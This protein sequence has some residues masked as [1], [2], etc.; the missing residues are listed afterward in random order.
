MPLNVLAAKSEHLNGCR[1]SFTH[2]LNTVLGSYLQELALHR[3][4]STLSL[5]STPEVPGLSEGTERHDHYGYISVLGF[6]Q[7]NITQGWFKQQINFSAFCKMLSGKILQR[8]LSDS[9][10]TSLIIMLSHDWSGLCG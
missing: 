3:A 4:E 7:Q 6:P 1:K 8:L 10:V 2:S 5:A 9:Q